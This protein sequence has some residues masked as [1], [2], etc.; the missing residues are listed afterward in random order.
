MNEHEQ[1]Y[2]SFIYVRE[3]PIRRSLKFIYVYLSIYV[4][5]SYL[6]IL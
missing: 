1:K 6:L 2:C 5:I 4:H 3:C